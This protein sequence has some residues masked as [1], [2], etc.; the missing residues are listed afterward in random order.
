MQVLEQA[1]SAFYVSKTI[2]QY[3]TTAN[4]ESR[5]IFS[6][7]I[8]LVEGFHH[9]PGSGQ[10]DHVLQSWNFKYHPME[11]ACLHL[12]HCHLLIWYNKVIQVFNYYYAKK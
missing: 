3:S 1:V 12:F 4:F 2:K 7:F 9:L 8:A 6:S 10:L 11:I 5:D